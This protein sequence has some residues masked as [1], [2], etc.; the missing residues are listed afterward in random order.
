MKSRLAFWFATCGFVGCIPFAPGTFGSLLAI[1]LLI[2]LRH[3]SLALAILFFFLLVGAILASWSVSVELGSFDPSNVVIDEV[4]GMLA[5]FLFVS[6]RWQ[7][8]L[9]GFLLF[10]FFD[11]VKPPPIRS[12]ERIPHGFG[13][14]FDDVGA[15]IY[16]NLIL[17]ALIRYAHL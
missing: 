17:Q 4:C 5:S 7:T 12:I 2:F 1:P 8:V 14:V 11:I 10:R 16:T 13:I 3:Q 6:I 15:G 9:V